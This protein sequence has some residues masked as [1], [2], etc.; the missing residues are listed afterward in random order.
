MNSIIRKAGL[1]I[2]FITISSFCAEAQIYTSKLEAGISGGIF[3]YQGDLTPEPL[4]AYATIRPQFGIFAAYILNRSFSVRGNFSFGGLKADD[5]KYSAPEYRK[6]RAFRFTTPVSEFSGMLVWDI[7]QKNG[8]EGRRGFAPYVFAGAG[9]SLLNIQRDWSGYNAA[10]F[11][12]ETVSDGLTADMAHRPPRA[13]PVIPVGAGVKYFLSGKLAI[14]AET[15]YRLMS[16]D[17]LDGFSQAANPRKKDNYY[18]HSIG[19]VLSLG[20]KDRNDCPVK[21]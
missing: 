15:N 5:A 12:A 1:A 20:Y 16:S 13:L 2:P 10:Y 4:G 11:N 18:S 17:Y 21:P 8:V 6:Q 9:V 14:K 3:I 19:I 7:L